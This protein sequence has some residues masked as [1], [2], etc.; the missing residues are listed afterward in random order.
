MNERPVISNIHK[1]NGAMGQ[2]SV[3]ANVTL[4]GTDRLEF[5]GF[6]Y[7]VTVVC[8]FP[9]GTQVFVTDP[10]RHGRFGD[11]PVAWVRRYFA[12]RGNGA[13]FA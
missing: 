1:H 12:E 6:T 4:D 5:V 3:T 10:G 9:S 13:E 2:V 8:I 11:D 7:G